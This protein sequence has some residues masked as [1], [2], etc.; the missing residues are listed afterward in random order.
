MRSPFALKVAAV[1]GLLLGIWA[2]A[3]YEPLVTL[4]AP[5]RIAELLN[6]AGPLRG[7]LLLIGM[8][9]LAGVVGPLPNLPLAVGA[10]LAF[11]PRLGTF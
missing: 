6:T 8:M 9:G 1:A 10:R 7:P 2:L 5:E 3:S 4:L 11:G